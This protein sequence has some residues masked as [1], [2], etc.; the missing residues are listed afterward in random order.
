MARRGFEFGPR[1]SENADDKKRQQLEWK[2]EEFGIGKQLD[3]AAANPTKKENAQ[4]INEKKFE[5]PEKKLNAENEIRPSYETAVKNGVE[6]IREAEHAEK[7]KNALPNGETS[8]NQN[9]ESGLEI[10]WP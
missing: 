3:E 6:K 5:N 10:A 9:L 8:A 7:Q 2:A 1:E 4:E